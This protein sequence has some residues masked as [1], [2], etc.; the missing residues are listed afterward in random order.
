MPHVAVK[1]YPG[2]SEE[3]KQALALEV[4]RTLMSVLGSK[5]ESISIG[6]EEVAPEDWAERVNKPD[7]LGKPDTIYRKPGSK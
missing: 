2:R 6:I 4:A 5:P 1:L 7:V 3:Q